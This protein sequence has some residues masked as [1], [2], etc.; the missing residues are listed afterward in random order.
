MCQELLPIQGNTGYYKRYRLYTCKVDLLKTEVFQYNPNDTT[1]FTKHQT[2]YEYNNLANG[3]YQSSGSEL[4]NS[5][6]SLHKSEYGYIYNKPASTVKS[7]MLSRNIIAPVMEKTE[8]KNSAKLSVLNTNY[9]DFNNGHYYQSTVE[10]AQGNNPLEERLIYHE[11]DAYGNLK[12]VSKTDG[13]HVVYLWGYN[14]SFLVAKI[15]GAVWSDVNGVVNQALL[16]DPSNSTYTSPS[17]DPDETLRV[18]L[19]KLRTDPDLGNALI[20]TMTYDPLIGM[21]SQT[22]PNGNT[23][24]YEYD[25][26]GRLK[27][28]KDRDGNI[29]KKNEY[30]YNVNANNTNNY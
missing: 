13:T 5:D 24:F 30:A 18:E 22:M 19:N 2:T 23:I 29:L 28:I 21:T 25:S 11:Y 27:Y 6:E 16:N 20:T 9:A 1:L 4:T 14:E 8:Y 12:E 10:T 3:Y 15:E 17:G 7:E 26:F